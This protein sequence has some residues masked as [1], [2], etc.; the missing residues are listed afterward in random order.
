MIPHTAMAILL[1]IVPQL[2]L[3]VAKCRSTNMLGCY[4]DTQALRVLQGWSS[5]GVDGSTSEFSHDLLFA[6]R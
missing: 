2:Q 3:V 6:L 1:L 4:V 5:L